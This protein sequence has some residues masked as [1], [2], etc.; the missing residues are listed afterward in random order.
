[1][2]A[3]PWRVGR[4]QPRNLYHAGDFVGVFVGAEEV[5]EEI[6]AEVVAVLNEAEAGQ[7]TLWDPAPASEPSCG[8]IE[9]IDL[10]ESR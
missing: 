8:C 10:R 1:M 7:L 3:G 4:H 2:T 6:A 9:P 5:A